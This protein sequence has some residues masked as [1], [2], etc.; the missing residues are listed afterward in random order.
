MATFPWPSL[1]PYIK[2]LLYQQTKLE[3]SFGSA[4]RS[5][6]SPRRRRFTPHQK[7]PQ[8]RFWFP[9]KIPPPYEP[10]WSR[11]SENTKI[12]KI[13]EGVYFYCSSYSKIQIFSCWSKKYFLWIFI[14]LLTPIVQI[15][16]KICKKVDKTVK[17]LKKCSFWKFS[18]EDPS[19]DFFHFYIFWKYT[20][21]RFIWCWNCRW[22]Q[23]SN[24]RTLLVRCE[25]NRGLGK[26][27]YCRLSY[28]PGGSELYYT[29][30]I[31]SC[32]HHNTPCHLDNFP[33]C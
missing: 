21:L 33:S 17:L 12:K 6:R 20:P 9:A 18:S 1:G 11:L 7:G 22:K 13:Y 14:A 19:V 3:K 32:W 5:S 31:I 27:S 30:L 8:V 24:L 25:R 2:S 4:E 10:P 23:K 15:S 28:Y 16:K 29:V 26:L